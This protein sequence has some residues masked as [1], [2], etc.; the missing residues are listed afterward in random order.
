MK[1][2]KIYGIYLAQFPF[3]ELREEKIRPVIVISRPQG[4]YNV[5]A[6][7]PVSSKTNYEKVDV[8]LKHWKQEKL[9][10]PSVARVHRLTAM[11]QSDLLAELG[12]L[13][14]EDKDR[15]RESLRVF[16]EL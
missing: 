14:K 9:I 5:V 6:V 16:L 8:P 2:P 1:A 3:L 10:K 13:K 15:L 12:T 4:N 7:I 11:L